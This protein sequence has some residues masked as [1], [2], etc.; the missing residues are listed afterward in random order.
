M[1]YDKVLEKVDY[2]Q[3]AMISFATNDT[4]NNEE[5]EQYRSDIL[6]EVSFGKL[7]PSILKKYRRC[8]EFWPFI[9][10]KFSHYD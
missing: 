9:K 1:D 3:N 6:K 5:Y 10:N 8:E 7:M 2:L 4:Y